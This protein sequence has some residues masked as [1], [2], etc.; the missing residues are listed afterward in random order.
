VRLVARGVYRRVRPYWSEASVA[1]FAE[2]AAAIHHEQAEWEQAKTQAAGQRVL[3][4][5]STGGNLPMSLMEATL[6]VGLTLRGAQVDYLLCDAALPACLQAS[7]QPHEDAV[8]TR[9]GIR[10]L[11]CDA[12]YSSG[13]QMLTPL[14]LSIQRYRAWLL[15][16]EFG[17]VRALAQTLSLAELQTYHWQD[18]SIGEHAL[19]GTLRYF[20]RGDLDGEPDA[21]AVMRHYFVA[22]LLTAYAVHRLLS[23]KP[24]DVV[25]F[26]H[27][28]YVP[29]GVIGAVARALGVRVVNWNPAYR[30]HCFI[31]SHTDTYHH[32]LMDEPTSLWETM[33]WDDATEADIMGYLKSRWD[34]AQDWIWFHNAPQFDPAKISTQTGIDFSKP[35]IALLTNVIWDAQL[36][37]PA[38]AFPTMVAW[39]LASIAYFHTRPDLQLVIRVHPAELRGAVPSRQRVVDEIAKH[40]PQLPPNVFVISPDSDVSTYVLC[41]QCDSVLI[42]GTKT[43]VELTSIGIPVIVAGEAW[44]R[45]KGITYD[46][47]TQAEYFS[48]LEQL[49]LQ[50]R[51]DAPQIQRARRYAYHFF[52]RRMIPLEFMKPTGGWPPYVPDIPD[53]A[54][55]RE[56]ADSGFDVI[57]RGILDQQ[58]FVFLREDSHAQP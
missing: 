6:G 34:G 35:T 33:R 38:N 13:L 9:D 30:K 22:A 11:A 54:A 7:I 51:L 24:Y 4:A 25:C 46:A 53:L 29:Q 12:C 21:L 23:Q 41:S 19:A 42:Y 58:P 56:G 49:P 43:G 26:H 28:I 16:G 27:G 20:A 10:P 2:L 31:F 47:S 18:I 52:Y 5:T 14:G 40:Y 50:R 15:S 36:H 55:L 37:Y 48:L 17:Q 45:N 44:I 8:F 1:P 57:C 3:I 32:T 39:L